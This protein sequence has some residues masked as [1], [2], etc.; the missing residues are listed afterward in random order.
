MAAELYLEEFLRINYSLTL[1]WTIISGED[2][3]EGRCGY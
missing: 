3:H 2:G 1:G